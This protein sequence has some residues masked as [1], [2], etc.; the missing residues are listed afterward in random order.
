MLSSNINYLNFPFTDRSRPVPGERLGLRHLRVQLWGLHPALVLR[1][2][3][4]SD[5]PARAQRQE[6]DA[7]RRRRQ[8]QPAGAVRKGPESAR[9]HEPQ[10]GVRGDVGVVWGREAWREQ[11]QQCGVEGQLVDEW[12]VVCG[13]ASVQQGTC[14]SW[15]VWWQ[16]FSCTW[17]S[18]DLS[19]ADKKVYISLSLCNKVVLALEIQNYSFEGHI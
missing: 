19:H 6:E 14:K 9:L 8:Q 11:Q 5:G 13:R 2:V 17:K 7:E 16:K 18:H 3:R 15:W 1:P 10:S 12:D 4:L